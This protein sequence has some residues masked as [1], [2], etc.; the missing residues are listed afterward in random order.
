M[1]FFRYREDRLPVLI[2]TLVA[3]ADLALFLLVDSWW[4][5]PLWTLAMTLP[6]GFICAWNHHHQHVATFRQPVLN[7]LIELVFALQTGVSS[8]AWVLHHSLGHHVNYLDQTKDESRWLRSDGKPMGA[9]RYSL[10]V[11]FTSYTRAWAVSRKYPHHRPVFVGMAL[12]VA[13]L[14]VAALVWRPWQALFVYVLP[15][16]FSLVGTAWATHTHHAGRSTADHFVASTNIIHRGYNLITGN[17]GFHTAHHYRPGV[18][19]SRLPQL[20]EE[21]RH[22]IPSDAYMSPGWPFGWN[23]PCPSP[24]PSAPHDDTSAPELAAAE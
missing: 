22:R 13:A 18:H 4:W 8:H 15:M 17:L 7:R 11:T 19:W 12:L 3:A 1:Q 14:V 20:H 5:L 6:K 10:E 24:Y 23:E 9:L 16:F 21:I 2:F